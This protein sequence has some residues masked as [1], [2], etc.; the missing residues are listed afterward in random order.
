MIVTKYITRQVLWVNLFTLYVIHHIGITQRPHDC[1]FQK[2]WH[3]G[4]T[5]THKLVNGRKSKKS[6]FFFMIVTKYINRQVLW[7]NLF[8][9][10]VIHHIGITQRPHDHLFQKQWHLGAT[11]VSILV[12]GQKSRK[13]SFFLYDCY[14]IHYQIG[15]KGQFVHT[16]CNSSYW[17]HKQRPHDCLF[18]KQWHLG[19]TWTHELVNGRKSSFFFMIVTKYITRQVLCVNLFTLYVIHHIG[20]TQRP[21]DNL[22]PK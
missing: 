19:A 4:A 9:L 6:S 22:F 11:W 21:H 2:Q 12:N 14:E 13:S 3:L 8:T 18:Q 17:Y 5:W 15:F 20:I 7:V 16:I 10:Y 1:L